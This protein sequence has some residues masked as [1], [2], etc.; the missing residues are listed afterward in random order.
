MKKGI[1]KIYT[2]VAA[3][4]EKVNHVL[5]LGLDILWRKKAAA[6]AAESDPG[7]CLDICSGTGEMAQNLVRSIGG[8]TVVSAD[9][10]PEMLGVS[11][12]R[13]LK[14][15]VLFILT[16][17]ARLSFADNSFDLVIISFA[18][19]NLNSNRARLLAHLKEFHRVLKPG[20]PFIN[21]ETSQPRSHAIRSL[22]HAYVR[23]TVRSI[24]TWI[25]GSKSGYSY[26]AHTIPRFYSAAQLAEILHEAGFESVTAKSYLFGIAALHTAIKQN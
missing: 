15:P 18:T 13:N 11:R 14:F 16:D 25:S 17:A 20:C 19:R 5:T 21:L 2:E 3:T 26:L 12:R 4:Y 6:A 8:A 23:L 24:G 10:S 9:F 22:F 1:Q 7:L